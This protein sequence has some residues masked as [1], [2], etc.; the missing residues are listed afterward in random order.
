MKQLIATM[1]REKMSQ[2]I[3]KQLAGLGL[4]LGLVLAGPAVLPAAHA[5]GVQAP[6]G[7]IDI[8]VSNGKLIQL[9]RP[10]S[11]VFIA[12]PEVADVQVK[13]PRMV[14]VFG[15][16]SGS[17]SLYA[18]S[19]KD[20]VLYSGTVR[21][22]HNLA[23]VRDALARMM[24]G[25]NLDLQEM[26]GVLILTGHVKTPVEAA[27]AAAVAQRFLGENAS[28]LNRISVATP[29]QVNI[30][31]RVAEVARDVSKQLGF[32]WEGAFGGKSFIGIQNAA[33]VFELI[34][35][36]AGGPGVIKN[37]LVG[38]RGTGSYLGSINSGKLDL[39]GVIDALES[40]GFLTVLAEPNL[41]AQSGEFASFLA[42]GEFPIPV[43]QENGVITI[44]YRS[45][46][47]GLEF[48]PTVLAGNSINLK[49]QPEV[50]QLSSAGSLTLNGFNI[51]ALTTRRAETTVELASGQSFAIAGLLQ[52]NI[53]R[54]LQK[55]PGLGDIP[56]LGAL[57]RSDRFRR[58]ETEL[59]II[60]TPYIVSP[61][62][63]QIPTPVDGLEMP[64][65]A[66]RYLHGQ[67]YRATPRD[68]AAAADPGR[69]A[70]PAGFILN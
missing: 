61:V 8:E 62:S 17:T 9:S 44:E 20:E 19:D 24:P 18:L 45:F 53:E 15:K 7:A 42:G 39:N 70:A 51:P 22:N 33:D 30:R 2:R 4:G 16:K 43:P 34:P 57:F 36:P 60:V 6:N 50:S 48:T 23:M 59:I 29:T 1:K 35:D 69:R 54:E 25:S 10:A 49:I 56:I 14:Y 27:D 63:G 67:S 38:N 65:D 13:S 41:T 40:E 46:G 21:V 12:D 52:N 5:A 31:V 37:F 58:Q 32:N 47:V 55:L 11:S 3:I 68:E 28:V 64:N 26:G 66:E